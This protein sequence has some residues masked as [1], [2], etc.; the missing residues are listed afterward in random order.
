MVIDTLTSIL[1]VTNAA[2]A[3]WTV[4]QEYRWQKVCAQCPLYLAAHQP[5]PKEQDVP[6]VPINT[7]TTSS[8]KPL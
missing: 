8:E 5:L 1:V 2:T 4:Y 3:I 7:Q 6:L